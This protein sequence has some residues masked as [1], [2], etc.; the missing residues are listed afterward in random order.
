MY[1][2]GYCCD[3]YVPAW[4]FHPV[5]TSLEAVDLFL[6]TLVK[7][8][9]RPCSQA[10]PWHYGADNS[11]IL[12]LCTGALAAAAVSCSRSLLELIPIAVDAV[13]IAFRTGML[14]MDVAQRVEPL[15]A[16][17]RSWSIIVAGAASAEAIPRL[18]E[19]TVRMHE[20]FCMPRLCLPAADLGPLRYFPELASLISAHTR[21]SR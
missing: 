18:C 6:H 21:Q 3:L 2:P 17:D 12:G 8:L 7:K 4:N 10:D 15:D 13:I 1:T 16:S 20:N 9:N 11:R 14:V 5:S 19:Q